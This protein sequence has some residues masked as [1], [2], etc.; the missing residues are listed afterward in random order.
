MLSSYDEQHTHASVRISIYDGIATVRLSGS[1]KPLHW[2]HHFLPFAAR[3]EI[4]AGREIA[5]GI[6]SHRPH[7]VIIRGY[8]LG[9][10]IGHVVATI[11]HELGVRSELETIGTKRPPTGYDYLPAVNHR[12]RGD[13]IPFMPPWRDKIYTTTTTKPWQPLWLAHSDY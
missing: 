12:N 6:L 3:R 13:W 8:S 10:A 1:T 11:L 5:H 2:L 7:T 4:N 9:G